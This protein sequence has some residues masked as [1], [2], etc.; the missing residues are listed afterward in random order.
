[1]RGVAHVIPVG[2]IV[3]ATTVSLL[4]S[5]GMFRLRRARLPDQLID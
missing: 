5:G 4:L 3:V 2:G 1:M